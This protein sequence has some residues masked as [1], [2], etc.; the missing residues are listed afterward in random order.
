M[1]AIITDILLEALTPAQRAKR[2][3]SMRRAKSRIALGRKRAARKRADTGKLKQ[4][5]KRQARSVI[6]KKLS[7]GKSKSE[8]SFSQRASIEKQLKK[9]GAAIERIAKKLLPKVRKKDQDKF[10]KK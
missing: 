5:A 2:R 1:D 7:K 10:K 3:M 8:M 4:R 6:A 9:K